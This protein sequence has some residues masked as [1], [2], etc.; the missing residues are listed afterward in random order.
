MFAGAVRA[1]DGYV[2]SIR[3]TIIITARTS[4]LYLDVVHATG[5]HHIER[6]WVRCE[7]DICR[8]RDQAGPKSPL[9]Q[10]TTTTSQDDTR[11]REACEE[12]TLT[13]QC[14]AEQS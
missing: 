8:A 9:E 4:H 7:E 12:D 11:S 5:R 2:V 10:T 3:S 14:F 6:S 1:I 13:V